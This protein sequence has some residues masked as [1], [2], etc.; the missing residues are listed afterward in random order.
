MRNLNCTAITLCFI[1][2]ATACT[3]ENGS[4][5]VPK[6]IKNSEDYLS[7]LP[8]NSAMVFYANFDALKKTSMGTELQNELDKKANENDKDYLDFVTK[9]GLDPKKDI[10]EIWVS[11]FPNHD[12]ET[13]GGAIIKGQFDKKRLLSYMEKEKSAPIDKETYEGQNIYLPEKDD[14]AFT[15]YGNNILLIGKSEWIK[16]VIHQA[17]N[18]GKSIRDNAKMM[19]YIKDIPFKEHIWGVVDL[20]DYADE[21]AQKLRK[22]KTPF[23]G[24]ESLENLTSIVFSTKVED[25]ANVYI[26]GNFT[27]A[28]EAG[29]VADMLNGFIAMGKLMVSD[30]R[31]AIDMLN[32]ID[33]KTDG[34]KLIIST[35]VDKSFFDKIKE[36]QNK[37]ANRR[38]KML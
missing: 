25:K 34:S 10:S 7:L 27:T 33:V 30:D 18:D 5:E 31:D 14:T 36:K 24:T 11:G 13:L 2:L 28:E 15:F 38:S 6:A 32:D 20:N 37:F 9:T 26:N 8:E 19:S 23:K 3:A 29:L 35:S 21:W 12:K 22:N 16:T 17:N 4:N 1:F